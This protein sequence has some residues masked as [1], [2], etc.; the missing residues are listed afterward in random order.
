M[1]KL[2]VPKKVDNLGKQKWLIVMD[3]VRLNKKTID[4][5]YPL[6][7]INDILAKLGR[8]QYF[9]TLIKA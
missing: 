4:N 1:Q 6:P 7:N 5:K 2:F 8:G 9:I 3:Y